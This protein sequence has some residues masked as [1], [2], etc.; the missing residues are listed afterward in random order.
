MFR[1][2]ASKLERKLER[3]K[4]YIGSVQTQYEYKH[5]ECKPEID[6]IDDALQEIYGLT[7]DEVA[8]LKEYKLKYRM[9]NGT[10]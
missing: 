1:I 6:A 4:K 8:F 3:T 7:D 10:I 9:S 5:R 2:L